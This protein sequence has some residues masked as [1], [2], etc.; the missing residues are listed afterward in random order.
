MM[1]TYAARWIRHS[2]EQEV[3]VRSR[4][5]RLLHY[6]ATTRLLTIAVWGQ[7]GCRW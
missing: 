7:A 6:G 1:L 2:I 4:P 3:V 5:A